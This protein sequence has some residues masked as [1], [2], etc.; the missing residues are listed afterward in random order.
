MRRRTEYLL[1]VLA[2]LIL[3]AAVGR[4]D[5]RFIGEQGREYV[6]LRGMWN[7]WRNQ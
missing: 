5:E 3:S 1:I 7:E 2:I 6:S 4:L